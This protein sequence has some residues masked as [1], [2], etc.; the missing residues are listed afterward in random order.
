MSEKTLNIMIATDIHYLSKS[1]N[2]G[3]EAFE[4]VM[5]KGDGKGMTYI[6]EI[7]DAFCN[8][9]KKR[10]PDLVLLLGDLTFNGEL[11]RLPVSPLG[12]K[13]IVILSIKK[14]KLKKLFRAILQPIM[15][16]LFGVLMQKKS[17]KRKTGAR[18]VKVFLPN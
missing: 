11:A 3:G 17:V 13:R 8:E 6:E 7:V 16:V 10:R 18:Q 2:D 14:S 12:L 1:I 9:V 5:E 15:T 4:N